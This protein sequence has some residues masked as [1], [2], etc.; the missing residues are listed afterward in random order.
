[1]NRS[2]PYGTRFTTGC[3]HSWRKLYPKWT[4]GDL[5]GASTDCR[6]CGELLMIPSEQF[7]GKDMDRYPF[8]VHMPLFHKYLNSK[9]PR[10]PADGVGTW[11]SEF[12]TEEG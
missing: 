3:G 10:W 11:Y 1:M 7:T 6:V 4:Q 9:D 8:T 12:A 5:A 2:K